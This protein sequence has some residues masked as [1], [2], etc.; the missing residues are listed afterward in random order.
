MAAG[1]RLAGVRVFSSANDL[2]Q[3]ID[4]TCLDRDEAVTVIAADRVW[5]D[6]LRLAQANPEKDGHDQ[7]WAKRISARQILTLAGD[8]FD[9]ATFISRFSAD[10][11]TTSYKLVLP[12]F[13]DIR[14]IADAERFLLS[15]L[16]KP[17]DGIISRNINRKIS[18]SIT[19]RLMHT[20]VSPNQMTA[21]VFLIG[22]LSG[23]AIL[24]IRDYWGLVLGGLLYYVSSVLDGCDGELSRLRFEESPFGAWLDTVVDDTVGLSYI[25]GLYWY[26]SIQEEFWTWAGAVA[27]GCYF[28]TLVP[29]Y[30]MLA[31]YQKDGDYQKLSATKP[32]PERAGWV[33]RVVWLLEDTVCRI[34]FI[35]FA[36]PVTSLLHCPELFAGLFM[37]GTLGTATDSLVTLYA[38]RKKFG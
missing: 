6:N 37:L 18:I 25:F 35:A 24:L 21:V 1:K 23:P 15:Q 26:L 9:T 17:A 29:R 22:V 28:L 31:V 27:V 33:A 30:Y 13:H 36:A 32:R 20:N 3:A 19:R 38:L 5:Q 2:L 11:I 12:T 4:E 16:E 7:L 10:G 34:D 14:N 8:F